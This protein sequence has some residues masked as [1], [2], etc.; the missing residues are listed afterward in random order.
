[1]HLGNGN[2]HLDANRGC[3]D[4]REEPSYQQNSSQE[5]GE[6][7]KIAEPCRNSEACYEL[8]MMVKTTENFVEAMGNHD[9][10]EYDPQYEESQR[11]NSIQETEIQEPI[12]PRNKVSV[13]VR[14]QDG[15]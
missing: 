12:L 5:F 1:M 10:S 8:R 13:I 14:D 6:G 2:A 7:R 3:R 15:S 9:D 4:P 11:L